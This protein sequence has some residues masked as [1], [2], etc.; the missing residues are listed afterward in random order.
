MKLVL[1]ISIKKLTVSLLNLNAED[2]EG[3]LNRNLARWTAPEGKDMCITFWRNGQRNLE[4]PFRYNRV[5]IH[6]TNKSNKT[7]SKSYY[8]VHE[9]IYNEEMLFDS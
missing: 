7:I 1:V 3:N 5:N 9:I 6:Y 2:I 4:N 8:C